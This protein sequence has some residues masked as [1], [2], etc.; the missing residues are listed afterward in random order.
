ML[1]IEVFKSVTEVPLHD[2]QTINGENV[3]FT[4]FSYLSALEQ[5]RPAGMQFRYVIVYDNKMPVATLCFQL[6]DVANKDLDGVLNLKDKG[7]LLQNLNKTINKL[8]FKCQT[9]KVNFLICCGSFFVSGE[10]GINVISR[11]V[12]S[13][14]IQIL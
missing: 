3:I 7:W 9:G 5:S 1:R 12:L 11:D 6:L 13:A 4:S 14:I 2:W 8:L 10:Y